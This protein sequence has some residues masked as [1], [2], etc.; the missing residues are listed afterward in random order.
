MKQSRRSFLPD[1]N[2]PVPLSEFVDSRKEGV[3]IY[4]SMN[5]D[6][7]PVLSILSGSSSSDDVVVVVGPEGGFDE[8]EE[9]A[10]SKSG[11]QAVTLGARRLRAETAGVAILTALELASHP[12]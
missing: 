5:V 8:Q 2:G 12:A 6:G 4:G 3:R 10:L 9:F 7:P 1:V 11:F